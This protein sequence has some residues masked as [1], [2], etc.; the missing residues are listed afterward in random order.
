MDAELQEN[1]ASRNLQGYGEFPA[2]FTLR[3]YSYDKAI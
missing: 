2:G 3:D 1:F